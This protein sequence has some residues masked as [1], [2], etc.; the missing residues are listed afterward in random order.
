MNL[1]QPQIGQ[2]FP[3]N[4]NNNMM[5]FCQEQFAN[6]QN[7]NSVT[8]KD[9]FDFNRKTETMMGENSIYCNICKRQETAY[10][11]SYIVTSPEIII[12]ILNRGK[13]IKFNV[14]LEFEEFLNL[15]KYVQ[16]NNNKSIYNLIGVVTYLGESGSS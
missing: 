11:Q 2:M 5:L 4:L 10:Y 14:K 16:M 13:G 9:C 6:Y 7:I 12:I 3:F 8:I 15:Q 1:M